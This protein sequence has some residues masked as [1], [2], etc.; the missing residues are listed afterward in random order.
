MGFHLR[1]VALRI[2]AAVAEA[3]LGAI[4]EILEVDSLPT[5]GDFHHHGIQAMQALLTLVLVTL[6][7]LGVEA[8]IDMALI[9]D[10]DRTN[11]ATEDLIDL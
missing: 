1:E 2:V 6:P 8:V 5:V 9:Q 3:Q 4:E 7:H 11:Q 10:L